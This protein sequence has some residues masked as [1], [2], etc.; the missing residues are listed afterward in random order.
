VGLFGGKG[1][2]FFLQNPRSPLKK[3][4][5]HAFRAKRETVRDS[6]LTLITT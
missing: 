3:Y 4:L 5:P 2:G 6:E 1:A